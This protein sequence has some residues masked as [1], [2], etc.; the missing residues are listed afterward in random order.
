MRRS[1][2]LRLPRDGLLPAAARD[3]DP[4]RAAL[5]AVPVPI[6]TREDQ[7]ENT[8]DCEVLLA[9]ALLRKRESS[10]KGKHGLQKKKMGSKSAKTMT[11]FFSTRI[12]RQNIEEKRVLMRRSFFTEFHRRRKRDTFRI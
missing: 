4:P 8:I 6:G 9:N 7:T 1:P 11:I 10:E 5:S 12:E 2:P 3:G